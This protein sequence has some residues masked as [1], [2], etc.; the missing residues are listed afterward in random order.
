MGEHDAGRMSGGYTLIGGFSVP[1]PSCLPPVVIGNISS[2]YVEIIP[3]VTGTGLVAFHIERG[4]KDGGPP[5]EG[6]VQLTHV[7]YDDGP[8]GLVNIG[9]TTPDC[10]DASF[11][12]PDA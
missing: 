4:A 2:R 6:W 11:L 9:K 8:Q 1:Q 7:D 5:N 3:D 12:T 10:A